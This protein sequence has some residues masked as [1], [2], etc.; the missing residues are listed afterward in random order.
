MQTPLQHNP[1]PP[2]RRDVLANLLKHGTQ[3]D[4]KHPHHQPVAPG[5]I[6]GYND[7]NFSGSINKLRALPVGRFSMTGKIVPRYRTV[8]KPDQINVGGILPAACIDM[9]RCHPEW[10]RNR[11]VLYLT[12]R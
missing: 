12:Y 7:P 10:S 9:N 3:F 11:D 8:E 4:Q 5:L 6:L 2:A 1:I